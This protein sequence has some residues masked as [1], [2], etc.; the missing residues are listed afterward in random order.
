M[1]RH[2]Q[3]PAYLL[4]A[5]QQRQAF[6]GSQRVKAQGT[7]TLERV[8]ERIEG[9]ADRVAIDDA[10]RTQT[11]KLSTPTDKKPRIGTAKPQ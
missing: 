10:A 5:L 8:V 7:N 1:F 4:T 3:P 6:S 9:R 2:R 11:R